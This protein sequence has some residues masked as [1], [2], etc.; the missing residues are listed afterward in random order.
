MKHF[1][2]LVVAGFVGIML[3]ALA[4]CDGNGGASAESSAFSE[5]SKATV[6]EQA[7][8]SSEVAPSSEETSS[9]ETGSSSETASTSEQADP[10]HVEVT[11]QLEMMLTDDN[12]NEFRMIIPKLIVDGKEATAIN[13]ALKEFVEQNHPLEKTSYMDGDTEKW[14]VD[15]EETSYEWGVKGNMVSI[16]IQADETFTDGFR[17]DIFNYNVDTLEAASNEEVIR[18]FGMTVD[19]FNG[20]VADAYRAY[21]NS[22]TYLQKYMADLDK[23]I[24]AI[25]SNVTPFVTPDG[26]A[27][28]AGLIYNSGSQFPERIK[29]FDLETLEKVQ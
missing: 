28:A 25:P 18:A 1:R 26:G 16:V 3:L 20:K 6:S 21:W 2:N 24:D 10:A 22:S 14:S 7:S 5:E 13:A 15:G 23:S 19:E 29:C 8:Q 12:G 9:S 11:T 17:Y 4:G 27:G